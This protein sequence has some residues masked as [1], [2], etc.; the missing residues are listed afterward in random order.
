MSTFV[1]ATLR[2]GAVVEMA[3]PRG[4]FT[5]DTGD[6]PVLLLS[7]GIGATPVLSMLHALVAAR[8]TREVWW[9]HGARNSSEHPFAAEVRTLL[10]QLP[11]VRPWSLLQRA[12]ADRPGRPGLHPTRSTLGRLPRRADP[13][14]RRARLHLR[15]AGVH[16][17]RTGS[18]RPSRYG[19]GTRA[20]RGV[21]SRSCP[22]ARHRG[23]SGD[24][25]APSTRRCRSR[26]R[27]HVRA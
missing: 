19:H 14:A 8:S 15:T 9:L 20:H 5:L 12:I 26:P 4:R 17:R 24:P 25:A 27:R 16:D 2:A 11:N 22:D 1:H 10:A 23:R 13:P 6:A 21:R 7:A 18:P 3:A